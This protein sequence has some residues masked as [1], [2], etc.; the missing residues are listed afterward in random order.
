MKFIAHLKKASCVL[1][2]VVAA[3]AGL[4]LPAAQIVSLDGEWR[5]DYFPQPDDGAVREVAAVPS[6]RQPLVSTG[7]RNE[8]CTGYWMA[9]AK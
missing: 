8:C 3:F 7:Q 6:A 5:L 9:G 2:T 1:A 4:A